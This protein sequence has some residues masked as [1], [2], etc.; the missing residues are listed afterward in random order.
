MFSCSAHT[1]PTLACIA[2]GIETLPRWAFPFGSS[3]FG[4]LFFDLLMMVA[5]FGLSIRVSF[6]MVVSSLWSLSSG[7]R[8][9]V[10]FFWSPYDCCLFWS[11]YSGLLMVVS[12]FWS[13]SSGLLILVSLFWSSWVLI[14]VS[15]SSLP[16]WL[17][18]L[19]H[20]TRMKSHLGQCPT[21]LFSPFPSQTFPFLSCCL[22][23]CSPLFNSHFP[24]PYK[25]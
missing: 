16:R 18:I 20:W 7:L 21:I 5:F 13:L 15:L 17:F 2:D 23:F 1:A 19:V 4:L 22:S 9:L 8:I 6:L 24:Y 14:Q 25:S 10:S 3:F 11:L 12:L